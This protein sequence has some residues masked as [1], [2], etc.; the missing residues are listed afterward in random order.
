MNNH[1]T[2]KQWAQYFSNNGISI[3]KVQVMGLV[4]AHTQN[5]KTC[6]TVL[7]KSLKL[8][9]AIGDFLTSSDAYQTSYGDEYAAVAELSGTDRSKPEGSVSIEVICDKG[10]LYFMADTL[11]KNGAA[12]KFALFADEKTVTEDID[13]QIFFSVDG[14]SLTASFPGYS[15]SVDGIG[16]PDLKP[17]L[18]IGSQVKYDFSSDGIY[19]VKAI[20]EPPVN[21]T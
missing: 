8:K 12:R 1:I 19:T 16:S 7:E 15:I 18:V 14:N 2:T 6:R 21:N 13:P 10:Q 9:N 4:E 3:E 5:C 11:E 20:L 17:I